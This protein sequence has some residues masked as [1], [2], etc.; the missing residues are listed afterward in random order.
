[1]LTTL[2]LTSGWISDDGED[3]DDGNEAH[4]RRDAKTPPPRL[5]VIG[6]CLGQLCHLSTHYVTKAAEKEVMMD[7]LAREGVYV[8]MGR[9]EEYIN[10][11]V[12]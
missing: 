3:E 10:S 5:V 4:G 7:Y 1:M 8:C 9:L 11:I 12:I 2:A 6:S